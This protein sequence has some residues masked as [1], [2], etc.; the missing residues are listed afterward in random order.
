MGAGFSF[1]ANAVCRCGP[2]PQSPTYRINPSRF[3]SVARMAG[4]YNCRKNTP[5]PIPG[6]AYFFG[7]GGA[8][9][10]DLDLYTV[11]IPLRC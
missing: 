4:S 11:E 1:A 5:A 8:L 2:C 3:E 6:P 9:A 10:E 7:S